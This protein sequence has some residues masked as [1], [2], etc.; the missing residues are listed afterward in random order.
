MTVT[1]LM[2][3]RNLNLVAPLPHKGTAM[4]TADTAATVQA[5][6]GAV[7]GLIGA[8]Q[9]LRP[10]DVDRAT[11]APT[12]GTRT[13]T[14]ATRTTTTRTTSSAPEP[15]ADPD[16]FARLVQAWLD[17]RRTKRNTASAL[18]F[19]DR[20]ERNLV[21]LH[22][23]LAAG[24]YTPG[25]SICF[26]VTR[27][28]PREVWAAAFRDRVVHHLL[29]NRIA[30]RFVAGFIADSCACI[31][32][33]GTLY[34]ARRLE[35]HVRSATANWARPAHY[36]KCDIANFFVAIDKRVLQRQLAA[37]VHEPWWLRLAEAILFHDPRADVDLQGRAQDLA[38]VP[39]HK[40][41][42]N[43]PA[44]T[45]LPIGNLSSQFFANVLLDALDQHVKH[46]IGAR[47]YVRYVDDMLLVHESPQWLNAALAAI[48]TFLADE[49]HCRLNPRKT[50]LQPVDRGIDFVGHQLKPW[51][52]TVR[53]RTIAA[54]LQ[55]IE[56][57]APER[58]LASGNSYLGLAGQASRGHHQRAAIARA[59]LRRGHSVAMDLH[60]AY[61]RSCA[62]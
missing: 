40:S 61:P 39:A 10:V 51:C 18:A 30:P 2:P 47:H 32:G 29:Y 17:C 59:L 52:R 4:R 14:T 9:P 62:A 5:R 8:Q 21:E 48:D 35:H 34:A 53:R 33:R 12:P 27:P 23:E 49:L 3:E 1:A 45:G 16:L 19:E 13:S 28:R 54:A 31:P 36:L 26:V 50:I 60:K 24:S 20:L 46:R 37:R 25:R 43:A 58:L 56:H 6:S 42:F 57:Q 11:V 41:L 38:R 44:D 55:R 7:G 22:D 15:S